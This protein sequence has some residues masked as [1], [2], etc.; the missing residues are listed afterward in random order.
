MP[1][2]ETTGARCEFCGRPKSYISKEA[3]EKGKKDGHLHTVC[4]QMLNK[5]KGTRHE[6]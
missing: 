5:S 1:L 3:F 6:R 4:R 2:A